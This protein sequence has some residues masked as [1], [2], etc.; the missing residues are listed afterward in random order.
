M[1]CGIGLFARCIPARIRGPPTIDFHLGLV[2]SRVLDRLLRKV[3]HCGSFP[4]SLCDA[5]KEY[6]APIKPLPICQPCGVRCGTLEHF[7]AQLRDAP[8][9][10]WLLAQPLL[11]RLYDPYRELTKERAL[12][13][14]ILTCGRGFGRFRNHAAQRG[15]GLAD[16]VRGIAHGLT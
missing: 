13:L 9:D 15:V 7:A 2:R 12:P 4:E 10:R 1:A 14:P 8:C 3:G 16:D 11:H 5:R 6:P